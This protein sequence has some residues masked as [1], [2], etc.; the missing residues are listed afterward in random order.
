MKDGD[1]EELHGFTGKEY[2][3]DIGLYY[4]NARWYDPDL[5]RFISEDP[6]GQGPNPYSYCGNSPVMRVDPT[7][8][9]WWVFALLGGLDSYLNGGDFMQGFVMGAITGAIGAGV[10][11][12]LSNTAFGAA[13]GSFGTQVVGGA[14]AGGIVGEISGEGFR[15]GAKFGAISG[16]VSWGVQKWFGNSLDKWAGEDPK[17]IEFANSIKRMAVAVATGKEPG[18][19]AVYSI[20]SSFKS[21]IVDK[22]E[23]KVGVFSTEKFNYTKITKVVV[24]NSSSAVGIAGLGFG[25][26]AILFIDEDDNGMYFSYNPIDGATSGP[27]EMRYQELD[28][29][30]VTTFLD[31][32]EIG[33][34][35]VTSGAVL[36]QTPKTEGK[37]DRNIQYAV[38]AD[39]GYDMF[40]V[41]LRYWYDPGQYDLYT[42]NCSQ[43]VSKMLEQGGISYSYEKIP[44]KAFNIAVKAGGYIDGKY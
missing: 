36:Y 23:S 18:E 32:G 2:D 15:E 11:S 1:F 5:G 43:V 10:G 25:H 21:R 29:S 6:A 35:N 26:S 34:V 38:S 33:I 39:Q 9:F 37:Y 27:G 4:F 12:A 16:A 24:L 19:A 17:K 7:G 40:K 30:E 22:L 42:H 8:E 41:A 20:V 3:P 13:I 31:T 14:I 44:N 28:S